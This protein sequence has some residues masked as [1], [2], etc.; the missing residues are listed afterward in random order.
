MGASK[1][2]TPTPEPLSLTTTESRGAPKDKLLQQHPHTWMLLQFAMDKCHGLRRG[3]REQDA[4]DEEMRRQGVIED[5]EKSDTQV[6]VR[7]FSL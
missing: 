4:W 6:G 7:R 5:T 3:S 1:S 2:N